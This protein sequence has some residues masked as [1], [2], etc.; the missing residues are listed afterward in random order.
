[1]P[2]CHSDLWEWVSA[3]CFRSC[4]I[5]LLQIGSDYMKKDKQNEDNE[6]SKQ[7]KDFQ[8]LIKNMDIWGNFVHINK[9]SVTSGK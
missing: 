3:F 7:L 6:Q 5:K 9:G 1:M 4:G 2:V 8:E